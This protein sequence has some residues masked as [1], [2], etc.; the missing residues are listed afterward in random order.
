[1][2]W[3]VGGGIV[4]VAGST[5]VPCLLAVPATL[6]I[7]RLFPVVV[8]RGLFVVA[9]IMVAMFWVAFASL[10]W[11]WLS[12]RFD[13]NLDN[14]NGSGG[15]F[16]VFILMWGGLMQAL[17]WLIGGIVAGKKAM[18]ADRRRRPDEYWP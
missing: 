10:T 12:A 8:G 16:V 15:L 5:V 17:A 11:P 9:T 3:I 7:A 1:M 4:L 2:L 13:F 6:V 18:R 14:M